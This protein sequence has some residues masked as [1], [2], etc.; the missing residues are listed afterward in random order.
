MDRWVIICADGLP[1]AD[2][3]TGQIALLPS[4]REAANWMIHSDQRVERYDPEKHP[5]RP[6][7][8]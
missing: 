3:E 4:V 1:L 2:F 7:T 6:T 5:K 8:R